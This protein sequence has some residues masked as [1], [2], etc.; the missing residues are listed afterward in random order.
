NARDAQRIAVG[1]IVATVYRVRAIAAGAVRFA[2]GGDRVVGGPVLAR[3]EQRIDPEAAYVWR[4]IPRGVRQ[5]RVELR[6]IVAAGVA[7]DAVVVADGGGERIHPRGGQLVRCVGFA[8]LERAPASCQAHEAVARC[9]RP[10]HRTVG[11]TGARG[12]CDIE[13]RLDLK[14]PS[15]SAGTERLGSA[16]PEIGKIAGDV[17]LVAELPG[18]GTC[19]TGLPGNA[20][21]DVVDRHVE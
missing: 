4:F 1:A 2:A 14:H 17:G 21:R 9:P 7:H 15:Q 11:D 5:P 19:A 18:R 3:R 13:L 20:F 12:R 16:N 8:D 6:A 10:L